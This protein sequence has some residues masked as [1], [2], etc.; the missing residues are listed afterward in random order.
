MIFQRLAVALLLFTCGAVSSYANSADSMTIYIDA[1]FS[2]EPQVGEAIELGLLTALSETGG[3][4]AGLPVSVRRFDHRTSPRRSR[5]NFASFLEDRTAIAVFGGKQSPPYLSYGEEINERQVPLLLGWS[6]AAPVTRLA[7]G[8]ANFI[9]RLSVDDTHAGPFLVD[10]ALAEGCNDIALIL[11]DTGWGRANLRT[12]TAAL[13]SQKSAPKV[14]VVVPT[15]IGNAEARNI[16]RDIDKIGVECALAVLT[17]NTGA[18]VMAALHE[19]EVAVDVLA[20]WGLVGAMF[21]Q[22]VTFE[23]REFLNLRML[24]T[25]GLSV[26]QAGSEVLELAISRAAAEH[27]AI[28]SLVDIEAHAGFVHGYDLGRIFIAA[29]VQAARTDQW[30]DGPVARRVALRDALAKLE[31]PVEGILK[32]YHPPFSDLSRNQRDGHDALGNDGFCLV[33]YD[34]ENRI[35]QSQ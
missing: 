6:A 4:V 2:L 20:H 22:N 27:A 23:M 17:G 31:Q 25:C 7:D 33:K 32:N 29:A 26:E 11:V 21:P 24:H 14:T 9:F 13:E 19:M 10:Q 5:R 18:A 8:A 3:Q 28:N 16:A 15:D 30:S 12:M 1:D 35:V 34:A